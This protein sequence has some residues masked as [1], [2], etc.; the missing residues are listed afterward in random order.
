MPNDIQISVVI[1][2]CNRKE[3]LRRLLASLNQSTYPI[4]EVIIV[5]ASDEPCLLTEMSGFENLRISLLR[6]EK[7]VC[8]QRNIGIRAAR[9]TWVFLCDDDLEV[10]ANYLSEIEMYLRANAGI[11]AVTGIVLQKESS[12]WRGQYPIKSQSTLLWKFL[13]QQSIWGEIQCPV[14][15][16][17]TRSVYS[18]YKRKGNHISKAGWP[19][20]TDFGSEQFTAPIYALGAA[21]I[22]KE[23]LLKSPYDEVLDPHGIGDNY[24]VAIGFPEQIIHVL[25]NAFV[26]HFREDTNRLPER[27]RYF[28]RVLALDYF[29]KKQRG[30]NFTNGWLVWSLIGNLISFSLSGKRELIHPTLKILRMM[31]TRTNPYWAGAQTGQKKVEPM[32]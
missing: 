5:D 19:V 7:S 29:F 17:L 32:L 26:Y 25:R 4:L 21:L 30:G 9:A 24:G 23:W 18:F 28:R 22:A 31:L 20:I 16:P 27:T 14:G 2:T 12:E 6:S 13:F 15:N 11:K 3:S 10:P 8:I 1:P